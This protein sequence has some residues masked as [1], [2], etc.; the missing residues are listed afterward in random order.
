MK[1]RWAA[2][3]LA[4]QP[5]PISREVRVKLTWKQFDHLA[6][7]F[8]EAAAII[9]G[10]MVIG[11]TLSAQASNGMAVAGTGLYITFILISLGLKQRGEQL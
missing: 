1:S 10:G 9:F 8:K 7:V 3:E 11:S 4:I 6:D 2:R 5:T